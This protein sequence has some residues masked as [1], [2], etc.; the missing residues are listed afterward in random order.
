MTR[1]MKRGTAAA[2][3]ALSAC[4]TGEKQMGLAPLSPGEYRELPPVTAC[5]YSGTK[6]YVCPPNAAEGAGQ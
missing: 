6:D 2:V 3:L 5:A 4:A 1:L